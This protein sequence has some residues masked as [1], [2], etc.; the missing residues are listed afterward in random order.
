MLKKESWTTFC[1]YK[2][3]KGNK[4]LV[5]E[6][7]VFILNIYNFG[8]HLLMWKSMGSIITKNICN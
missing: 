7:V 8:I 6:N 2:I 5:W 1:H 4:T 3:N